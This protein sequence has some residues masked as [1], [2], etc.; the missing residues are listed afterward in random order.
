M[1][2]KHKLEEKYT[3]EQS[4]TP[5]HETTDADEWTVAEEKALVTKLDWRIVPLVTVLYLLC[6]LDR[7][8]PP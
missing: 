3:R 6:F 2:E 8:R 4:T 5:S 1:P 7:Y